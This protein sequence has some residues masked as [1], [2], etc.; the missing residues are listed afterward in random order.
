MEKCV[1][2]W[3]YVVFVFFYMLMLFFVVLF[4]MSCV[5]LF[6]MYPQR[7]PQMRH[8]GSTPSP[9]HKH[10]HTHTHTEKPLRH[11]CP[12]VTPWHYWNARLECQGSI[13]AV[14]AELGS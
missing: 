7:C 9:K 12:V 1:P 10:T 13:T 4:I 3:L 5:F 2:L 6:K 8:Q 14:V 11:E